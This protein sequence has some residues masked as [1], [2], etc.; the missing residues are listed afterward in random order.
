MK[1]LP[2]DITAW[3]V[4]KIVFIYYS[5]ENNFLIKELRIWARGAATLSN[6]CYY[7]HCIFRLQWSRNSHFRETSS[8]RSSTSMYIL[9]MGHYTWVIQ[10]RTQES[11]H[12]LPTASQAGQ[13]L[14]K[15]SRPSFPLLY[16]LSEKTVFCQ[17]Q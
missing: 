12:F 5:P 17:T 16:F 3:L 2:Y 7:S 10:A 13:R 4:F 15:T 1:K 6:R 14:Q 8:W 11:F 9:G